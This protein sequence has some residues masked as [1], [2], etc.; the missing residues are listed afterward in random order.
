MATL[1][2]HSHCAR[3]RATTHVLFRCNRTALDYS[4]TTRL[5]PLHSALCRVSTRHYAIYLAYKI[6]CCVQLQRRAASLGAIRH[7]PFPLPLPSPVLS[8]SPSPSPPISLPP[9]LSLLSHTL[10]LPL[11]VGPLKPATGSGGSL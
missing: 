2:R 4:G 5:F 9:P 11:E 6:D 3:R 10:P 8:L 7:P 1:K